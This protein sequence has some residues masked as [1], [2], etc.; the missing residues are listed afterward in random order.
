MKKVLLIYGGH[1][2]HKPKDTIEL[3]LPFLKE[4]GFAL[5]MHDNIDI[6]GEKRLDEFDII[7]QNYGEGSIKPD[8][9]KNL[10]NTIHKGTGFAGWH[11]GVTD[12]FRNALEYQHMTGGQFVFHP[13]AGEYE[14]L[15]TDKEDEITKNINNFKI[16]SEQYYL[17]VD[18]SI[19]PLAITVFENGVRMPVVWKRMWGDGKVFYLSAGH[20]EKD[21][22]IPEVM[23]IMKRGIL[24][25]VR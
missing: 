22:R 2:F 25:A 19:K 20:D 21:F 4:N 17:H 5:E 7:I 1:E 10:L 23:E 14:V 13:P 16:N 15:I 12:A 9:E 6:Y 11:A 24:W 3:F 18:P 8:Q